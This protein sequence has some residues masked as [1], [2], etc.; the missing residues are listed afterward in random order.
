MTV[1]KQLYKL[2]DPIKLLFLIIEMDIK[3]FGNS[4]IENL[5]GFSS[6]V[7]DNK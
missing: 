4:T 2:G 3:E 6:M 1:L 5:P 7:I